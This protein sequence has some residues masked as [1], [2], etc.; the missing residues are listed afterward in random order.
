MNFKIDENLPVDLVVDLQLAGHDADTVLDENLAGATDLI[1]VAA[2]LREGRILLTLDKGIA[3]LIQH[4]VNTHAGVVL[5]RPGATG[6]SMVLDFIRSRLAEFLR[7]ELANR[8]TVVSEGRIR[9][10]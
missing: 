10:R 5:F 1:V 7:L 3:N 8:V 6:R 2:A 4:P 9:V